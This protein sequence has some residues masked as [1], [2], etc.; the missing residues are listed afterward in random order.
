MED[1]GPQRVTHVGTTS[2][3][4]K[5]HPQRFFGLLWNIA[6]L[7]LV[8]SQTQTETEKNLHN[9]QRHIDMGLVCLCVS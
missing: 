3:Q 7:K 5:L 4:K 8:Q 9:Q 1:F 6:G 2:L